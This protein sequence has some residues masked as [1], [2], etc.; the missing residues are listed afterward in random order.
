VSGRVLL[1]DITATAAT[2][3]AFTLTMRDYAGSSLPALKARGLGAGD[4]I[5]I[6]E[7]VN[8]DWSDSGETLTS[9][10]GDHSKIILVPGRYAVTAVL[11]TAGPV[12][13]QLDT[14]HK[15]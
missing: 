6:W 2:K 9:T 3:V 1:N 7:W 14:S 15:S 11:T 4:S 10:A 5:L 12:S 8:E 13:C